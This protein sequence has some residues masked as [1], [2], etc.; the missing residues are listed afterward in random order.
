MQRQSHTMRLRRKLPIALPCS[1][2]L[3]RTLA[4]TAQYT[5]ARSAA[6]PSMTSM[7]SMAHMGSPERKFAVS[8]MLAGAITAS[9]TKATCRIQSIRLSLFWETYHTITWQ[10]QPARLPC[11][12]ECCD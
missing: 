2:A 6:A 9:T 3:G 4:S 1:R 10:L 5:A 12:S 8:A 11:R 7:G